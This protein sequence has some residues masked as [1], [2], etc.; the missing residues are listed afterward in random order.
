M[1]RPNDEVAPNTLL[2]L[3][4]HTSRL[5]WG[6]WF[7]HI[8]CA[9]AAPFMRID[10]LALSGASI[11]PF[12]PWRDPPPERVDAGWYLQGWPCVFH[13]VHQAVNTGHFSLPQLEPFSNG[14]GTHP[15]SGAHIHSAGPRS[16]SCSHTLTPLRV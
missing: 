16:Q 11:N 15:F 1:L 6:A 5:S 7:C 4:S 2:N 8:A 9:L 14:V 3:L 10:C 12:P 13:R